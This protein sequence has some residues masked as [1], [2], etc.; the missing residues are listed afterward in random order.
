MSRFPHLLQGKKSYFVLGGLV[1]LLLAAIG[2]G[3]WL[4]GSQLWAQYHYRQAHRALERRD[5]AEALRHLK[6]CLKVWPASSETQLLTARTARR[7]GQY[8]EAEEHLRLCKL[9]DGVPEAIE[10][11]R[12][13][14]ATQRGDLKYE[15]YLQYCVSN[16]HPD[17]EIILE[18]L[19]FAYM[20]TYRLGLAMQCLN[21][22]LER[23]PEAVAALVW[24]GQARE[25][26]RAPAEALEDYR[27]AVACA[28]D[29]LDARQRLAEL[30]VHSHRAPE[31]LPHLEYLQQQR[32]DRPAVL[33]TLARCQA[34]LSDADAADRILARLLA[35]QPEHPQALAERGKLALQTGRLDD[36]ET[37]LRR[38]AAAAP[39]E[40]EIVY[41]F[42][43][44]LQQAGKKDEAKSWQARLEQIDADLSRVAEV[45]KMIGRQPEDAGLRCEA[46]Q[47]LM[48]NGQEE[49]GL[50]WLNSALRENPQ[51]G[52][53]LQALADFYQRNGQPAL[54]D[55]Y[56]QRALRIAIQ[57][58]P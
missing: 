7:A 4:A 35:E 36:A 1:L 12:A 52:P 9:A 21:F 22:W 48:R 8:D 28:P 56:R 43:Q 18:A 30:L 58:T 11:E 32:P 55:Q 53:T 50:R 14:L 29:H 47:L 19:V 15:T 54:A 17:T 51:H 46:G 26:L 2:L 5:L 44:C 3:G 42:Y 6:D 38:A 45:T 57:K 10:L 33:L 25:L 27:Q 20:K 49:E 16:D 39:Y 24:R 31:A 23:H 34:E 41:A 40:R 37:W 13:L